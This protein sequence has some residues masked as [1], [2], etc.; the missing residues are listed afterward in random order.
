MNQGW[1]VI[2]TADIPEDMV[3]LLNERAGT[4]HSPD[5]RVLT[6]LAELLTLWE[7]HQYLKWKDRGNG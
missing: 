7:R 1:K 5:G 4:A 6:T 2:E 3:E